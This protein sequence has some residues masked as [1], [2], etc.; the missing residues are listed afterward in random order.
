MKKKHIK[1]SMIN[2][3]AIIS[4]SAIIIIGLNF[5]YF[6]KTKTTEGMMSLADAN[7][8]LNDKTISDTEKITKLREAVQSMTGVTQSISLPV[9]ESHNATQ[10]KELKDITKL[11]TAA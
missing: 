7:K 3:L 11:S 4:V 9:D 8:V 10:V 2:I 5:L 1:I 6:F